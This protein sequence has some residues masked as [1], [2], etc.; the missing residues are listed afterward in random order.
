MSKHNKNIESIYPLSPMQQG[1]LFHTLY[2]PESGI[3]VEQLSC[4]LTGNLDITA[5]AQA[6]QKI[7][8]RHPILRTLFVWEHGKQPLQIVSKSVKLPW[9]FD[10]WQNFSE[11]EQQ[12]RLQNLLEIERSQGFVLDKA[13]LMR[14]TLIKLEADSYEF[15]WSHH[16]VLMDGWCL[17]I[18]LKE[19]LLFMK[20]R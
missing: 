3:Y 18:I 8:D 13:P 12:Q 4:T 6:W 9:I 7:V 10:D 20:Q 2:A 1:M 15:I 14:C 5:F 19:V 16:H 17:P 11:I